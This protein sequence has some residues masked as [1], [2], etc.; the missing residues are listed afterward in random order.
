MVAI[1]QAPTSTSLDLKGDDSARISSSAIRR[2]ESEQRVSS[3]RGEAQKK[4]SRVVG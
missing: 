3:V 4:S 1:K 2:G